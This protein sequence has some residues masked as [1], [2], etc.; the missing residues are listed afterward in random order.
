MKSNVH[1]SFRVMI[2]SGQMDVIIAWPLTESFITSVKWSGAKKY[3]E[4]KRS[5]W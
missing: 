1:F 3:M 2:Y 5:I 4:A